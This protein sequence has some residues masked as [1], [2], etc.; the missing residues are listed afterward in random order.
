M[1][2]ARQKERFALGQAI[3]DQ[4]SDTDACVFA[5]MVTLQF[6]PNVERRGGLRFRGRF[7]WRG[8]GRRA[9]QGR[10]DA[11]RAVRHHVGESGGTAAQPGKV[12][13]RIRS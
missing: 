11:R 1:I 12:L 9:D 3:V 8:R 5:F 13:A 6:S 10:A 2:A 7:G 4:A